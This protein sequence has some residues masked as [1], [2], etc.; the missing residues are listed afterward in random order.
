MSNKKELV[1]IPP[2]KMN[3]KISRDGGMSMGFGGPMKVPDF[4]T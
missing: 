1:K 4:I 2:P 3:P